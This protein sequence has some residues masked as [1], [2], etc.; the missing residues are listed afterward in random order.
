MYNAQNY[1]KKNMKAENIS[2]NKNLASNVTSKE[3]YM[4]K[5]PATFTKRIWDCVTF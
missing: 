5:N 2:K 4:R 3:K 1:I